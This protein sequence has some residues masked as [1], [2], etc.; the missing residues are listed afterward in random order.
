MQ[1]GQSTLLAVFLPLGSGATEKFCIENLFLS[2]QFNL[3]DSHTNVRLMLTYSFV[4]NFKLSVVLL[5]SL[6]RRGLVQK[7]DRQSGSSVS[8]I[9]NFGAL[10]NGESQ[11]SAVTIASGWKFGSTRGPYLVGMNIRSETSAR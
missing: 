6:L 3:A 1:V 8:L 5:G 11:S 9:C 10:M 7:I 2:L 4:I